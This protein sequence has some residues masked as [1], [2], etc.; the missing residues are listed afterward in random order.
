[1]KALFSLRFA[2]RHFRSSFWAMALSMIAVALGVA[3][4]VAIRLMNSTVLQGFLETVD[5]TA[6]RAN[7]VIGGD[8][9]AS[10]PDALVSK[11]TEVPG[12][13]LAVPLVRGVAFPN[14]ESGE[15][16]TVHGVDLAND[17]AVRVYHVRRGSE[18]LVEDLVEFLNQPDS[19]LL[20]RQF[21]D[22]RG[23]DVGDVLELVTPVGVR[24]FTIRGLLDP[25]GTARVLQG[26]LVVMDVYAAQPIFV[27]P[28]RINQIDVLTAPDANIEAVGEGIAPFLPSGI[29]AEEPDIRKQVMRRAVAAFQTMLSVFSLLGTMA[30][31][32]V[33]YGRLQGIFEMRTWEIGL[34]RAVGLRRLSVF[35]E[36]LKEALLLGIGGVAIGV[37]LGVVIA[38]W[39]L[40]ILAKTTAL[41][42]SLP[43]PAIAEP[44]LGDAPLIGAAVGLIAALA[45]AVA[46]ASR[47]ARKS[48]VAA[49]SLR[50]RESPS[51]QSINRFALPG[52]GLAILSLIVAQ[53]ALRSAVLGLATTALMVVGAA[54]LSAPMI[55]A[56]VGRLRVRSTQLDP[57]GRLVVAQLERAPRGTALT[58]TTLGIGLGT[59]IMI[60]TLGWSFEKSIVSVLTDRYAASLVITSAFVRGGYESA[61]LSDGVLSEVSRVPGV[62]VVAGEQH[63][64]ISY[65]GRSVILAAFDSSC[66]KS[67]IV[68]D[69]ALSRPIDGALRLVAEG[70]AALVSPAFSLQFGAKE[71]DSIHLSSSYG[72]VELRIAAITPGQPESAIVL[73]RSVYAR[74]WD[75]NLVTWVHVAT[76][77]GVAPAAVARRLREELGRKYRLRVLTS[78]EMI[79]H[80]ASQVRE[81][82]SLQ[83]VLVVVTLFLVLVGVGDTLAAAVAARRR[84]FG[85]MRAVGLH[86]VRLFSIV[87]LEGVSIGLLGLLLAIALGAALSTFWVQ[88]QFPA[89][90]GWTLEQHFP[91]PFVIGGAVITMMVCVIGA[92]IPS[93][94]AASLSPVAALRG[95]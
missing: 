42:F 84:Q 72:D 60:G 71:G 2:Y 85:M 92:L 67:S 12:V 55:R 50:G 83:Y 78:A 24:S 56:I 17:D 53:T 41:N 20:G 93:V 70:K 8:E 5:A 52:L 47:L 61:P 65:Q 7:L 11:I 31:F 86:R 62:S 49:L 37:P 79:D 16:L 32:V 94:R 34:L 64:R 89:L 1:M 40:P 46:P 3:L 36:L 27:G 91:L 57:T 35:G 51:A 13:K 69:W 19:I 38:R 76:D 48:P 68:C 73:A 23:L 74:Q 25:Q 29:R 45:A 82:F 54:A 63:R 28:G 43:I 21:A 90:L 39:S 6:G 14:D 95:E 81:A 9:G 77:A 10:F 18:A 44:S 26:R 15:L 22:S 58:V 75:D 30:G 87:M 66:F 80:F 59:V 4:V 33:C 88:V